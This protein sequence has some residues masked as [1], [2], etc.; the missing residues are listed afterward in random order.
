M[1]NG[2]ALHLSSSVSCLQ[3]VWRMKPELG[4]GEGFSGLPPNRLERELAPSNIRSRDS[5]SPKGEW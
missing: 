2:P 3:L 1:P 4:H 5:S